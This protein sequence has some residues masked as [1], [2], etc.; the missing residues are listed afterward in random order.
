MLNRT[1]ILLSVLLT[2]SVLL[3]ANSATAADSQAAAASAAEATA[4]APGGIATVAQDGSGDYTC[5]QAAIND[6]GS[7]EILVKPGIYKE[8]ILI[9]KDLVIRTYDGPYTTVIDGSRRLRWTQGCGP[10]TTTQDDTILINPSVKVVI[11][12]FCVTNGQDGIEIQKSDHVT[13]R[14]CIFWANKN[15]GIRIQENWPETQPPTTIIY[16]CI[17]AA[18][19]DCGILIG[20][21]PVS[22]QCW[23]PPLLV[24]N[25]ILIG[26]TE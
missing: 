18:N 13:L 24:M 11:E 12:G 2:A 5:I 26:N 16:N 8:N 10:Q 4:A 15:N 1:L 21:R 9:T 25:S 7:T 3:L 17:S 23:C 14:N 20:F 19:G 22:W 6:F